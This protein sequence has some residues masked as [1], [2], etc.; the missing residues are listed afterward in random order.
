MNIQKNGFYKLSEFKTKKL[1]IEDNLSVIIFDDWVFYPLLGGDAWKAEGGINI[2]I[3]ENSRV[4]FYWLL[5]KLED[6]KIN[7]IQNKNNSV[8]LIRYLLLS[9]DNNKLKTR[10]YSE[11]AAS[12]VKSNIH[13]ISIVWNEGFIDID[14]IIQINKDLTKAEWSLI[15]EN[16][17]LGNTWKV[18][19]KPTLLVRSADVK[20]SHACK[21]EKISDEKLFYLRS[22][23]VWKENALTMMI[24]AKIIKL[25][26][27]LSMVDKNFY[28]KLVEKVI[29][30]IK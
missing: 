29:E 4:E 23:W 9:K 21:M 7:F 11:L 10:I 8:L 19:G 3:W 22:R 13:I 12:F 27:C 14:W 18:N 20:A 26:T 2:N 1:I 6:Y 16:L 24:D 17:F 28:E 25:F 30:K 15:E 5:E